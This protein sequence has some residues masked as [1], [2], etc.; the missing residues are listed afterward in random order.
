[1][2]TATTTLEVPAG[3]I[4]NN[5]SLSGSWTFEHGTDRAA[6]VYDQVLGKNV[7]FPAQRV[8]EGYCNAA[9]VPS[10]RAC[11]RVCVCLALTL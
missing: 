10:V 7:H 4:T 3:Y 1:M 11:V 5:P 6:V 9:V 2:A 8:Q